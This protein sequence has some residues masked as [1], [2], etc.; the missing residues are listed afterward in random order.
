MQN[1]GGHARSWRICLGAAALFACGGGALAQDPDAVDRLRDLS[2]E[3]LAQVEVT[4]VAKR[5]QALAAAPAA[6]FV[7]SNDDIRRSGAV[8]LAEVLRLAPNLQ[9]SRVDSRDYAISARGLNSFETANKLLVLIDGRSVQSPLYS[10]VEWDQQLVQLEDVERI[11]VIS[12]A[13]G[14]LWGANAVNGVINVIT[15]SARDTQGL[16]VTAHGGTLDQRMS[17]RYGGSLGEAGAYRAYVSAFGRGPTVTRSGNRSRDRWGGLQAGARADFDVGANL[18][19]VQGELFDAGLQDLF[20]PNERLRGSHLLATWSRPLGPGQAEIQAYYDKQDRVA[21]GVFESTSTWDIEGRYSLTAGAHTLLVGG[22][23]RLSDDHFINRLNNAIVDPPQ[24]RITLSNIF[25]HD[26]IALTPKLVL[27]AGLKFEESSYHGAEWAPNLRLAWR[28]TSD[29]LLWAS[30][31]RAIRSPSRIERE[32]V[33]APLVV[34][35]NFGPEKLVAYEIGYRGTPSPRVSLSVSAFYNQYDDIRINAP[36]PGVIFP[37]RV[38]NGL[39]GATWGVEAWGDVEVTS[40]WRLGLGLATLAKDFQV[41]PGKA[42]L[43]NLKAAGNDPDYQVIVRSQMRLSE[44]LDLDVSMRAV[45]ELPRPGVPGY[46]EADARLS[47]KASDAIELAVGGHNLLDESHP[48]SAEPR[49]T[50]VRRDV[51]LEMRWSY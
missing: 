40:R 37:V 42:D 24:R 43:S 35:G 12:G 11:E 46:I 8:S 7:I 48:E 20:I 34:K 25:L 51:Y 6:V 30:V 50:E 28:P 4:S 3:E 26:D 44:R 10:G 17:L 39:E 5:P 16:A 27:T 49:S 41:Q 23:Y 1:R 47:W 9:V 14:S 2:L 13:G 22:G 45:D 36:T 33:I 31:S 29:S 21:R 15:R 32:L 38:A 19:T 18:F